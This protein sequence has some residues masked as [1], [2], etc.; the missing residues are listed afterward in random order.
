MT[1]RL[2]IILDPAHGEEVPG[3]GSP[4]GI[5]KEYRWSRDICNI[6]KPRLSGLGFKVEITN[7]TEKEI[8]LSRR[9]EF[10]TK[11]NSKPNETKFLVSLHNNAAGMGNDWA[12]ARGFEIYT[13]KGN[14]KSDEFAGVILNNLSKDFP[15]Y[16][17]RGLKE[18]NFTVLMGSGYSAVLIEWLF[19]DNKEDVALL[20]DCDINHKFIDSLIKSFLYIDDNLI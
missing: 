15:D 1:R 13:S 12:N 8:G 18:S 9:K 3:K 19:Q 14:T 6:L 7:P 5:H 10:A 16:K 2:V 4:D 11:V 20:K 17:N